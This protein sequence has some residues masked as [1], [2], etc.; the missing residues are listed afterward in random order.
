MRLNSLTTKRLAL[1]FVVSSLCY[2]ALVYYF[3]TQT[4]AFA[5]SEGEKQ[6]ENVLLTHKAIHSFVEKVQKP[7]VYR[8]KEQGHL[9]TD[10]FS[11]KLLSRTYI[12][13][14]IE[15]YFN[16]ERQNIGLPSLYFKLAA[17]NP[18]N[19][20]NRADDLEL[21]L[22]QRMRSGE[23]V[24]YSKLRKVDGHYSLYYAIPVSKT[25]TSCLQ[26]HGNPQMA[27]Q[28]L[29]DQ[30]GD[31]SAFNEEEGDIRALISIRLPLDAQIKAA[32]LIFV[33]LSVG[34]GILLLLLFAVV[35]LSAIRLE[36]DQGII[37]GQN[38]E[39]NRL[40]TV[41]MLTGIYNRQGFVAIME[42]ELARGKR[43]TLNLSLIMMDLDF[44]KQINDSYGHGIGDAV[45]TTI[46]RLLSEVKRT[47]DI[48]ARWGGEEFMI[49]CP[50]TDLDGAV[51]LAEKIQSRLAQQE[52]P[53]GIKI[54]ASFGV[55]ECHPQDNLDQFVDRVDIALYHS[56]NSGRNQIHRA[57]Y[58][59]RENCR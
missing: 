49:A 4:R 55:A 19:Q 14:G 59:N 44:F 54:T 39:L 58:E 28:E 8:L 37:L 36:R 13:R 1:F 11:P 45:L 5:F 41:D 46:G 10:Y 38:K 25:V 3:F 21:E 2:G 30:Y 18:R 43:H 9:Y 20:L 53:Q 47:S 23:L 12:A 6:I 17:E 34:T 22:L 16:L 24:T 40:A 51:K 29:V 31:T 7:E 48:V 35:S 42:Q 26:C 52:F 56:K 57:A 50:Q 33:R 32:H 15:E 27:P